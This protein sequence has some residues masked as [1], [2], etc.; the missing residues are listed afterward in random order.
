[1]IDILDEQKT[2]LISRSTKC[3]LCNHES[4]QQFLLSASSAGSPDLDTRPAGPARSATINAI[5][6]CPV[7][8]Y[9]ALEIDAAPDVAA[10]VV[11]GDEYQAAVTV[12]TLFVSNT[13]WHRLS[14][15][16]ATRWHGL[17]LIQEAGGDM[18][19]SGW[20]AMSTAWVYDDAKLAPLAKTARLRAVSLFRRAWEQ[21]QRFSDDAQME[22]AI[23][24]DLARRTDEFGPALAYCDEAE[25]EIGSETALRMAA[26]QRE[27]AMRRDTRCHNAGETIGKSNVRRRHA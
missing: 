4:D 23:L 26:L 25:R 9:C 7:C 15:L 20:S 16:L 14:V 27:F 8:G 21:S 1:M 11:A 24:A 10:T 22:H 12:P 19:A 6:Q 5:Q 2:R 17:S 18:S 3:A 13:K